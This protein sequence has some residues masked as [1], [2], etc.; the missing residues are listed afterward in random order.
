MAGELLS[1]A[2]KE[3]VLKLADCW[4][5]FI[6]LPVEHGDDNDE[7]RRAIHDAQ[8]TILGRPG[9]RQINGDHG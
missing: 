9:R 4:N 8:K 6:Q 3:V 7:F 1:E 2:E 5:L